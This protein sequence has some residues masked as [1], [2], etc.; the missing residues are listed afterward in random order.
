MD[1][2]N[3]VDMSLEQIFLRPINHPPNISENAD[4]LFD[5]MATL[6]GPSNDNST[7][8]QFLNATFMAEKASE[9]FNGIA[10]Q[11][12]QQDLLVP[13]GR[14]L[15]GAILYQENR[16]WVKSVAT[17]LLCIIFFFL[18][19][20][21]AVLQFVKPWNA[22]PRSPDTISAATVIL[23]TSA[24]LKASLHAVESPASPWIL[25]PLVDGRFKWGDVTPSRA[26][27]MVRA[28]GG[29]SRLSAIRSRLRDRSFQSRF[30]SRSDDIQG[31]RVDQ[32]PSDESVP[33]SDSPTKKPTLKP[34]R[35]F[36][37]KPPGRIAAIV[38]PLIII[39]ALEVIQRISDDSQGFIEVT[40]QSNTHYAMT[41][42][43][44]TMATLVALIQESIA[45]TSTIM[46]PFWRLR[47]G[48]APASSTVYYNT[49]GDMFPIA[50]WKSIQTGHWAIVFASVAAGAASF[51]SVFTTGLYNVEGVP[52]FSPI[53]L[54]RL[55]FFDLNWNNSAKEDN[56]AGTLTSLVINSNLSYPSW[57]F[58]NLA[59][60]TFA[61][62]S[63]FNTSSDARDGII[64]ARVPALRAVLNCTVT[65]PN[66]SIQNPHPEPGG[67]DEF[68]I[69]ANLRDTCPGR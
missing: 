19:L 29:A 24:D 20:G 14:S 39:V 63:D 6:S 33:K 22:A 38:A 58:D 45:S 21:S 10:S 43:P 59:F 3:A 47:M 64:T 4:F 1:L 7:L 55:D 30:S 61:V 67:N 8:G 48:N 27:E 68:I 52:T 40:S 15:T 44:A 32:L 51:L 54:D 36:I 13:D 50:I 18:I 60:P 66:E 26:R 56:G 49:V 9:A 37:I 53:S 17:I 62:A 28:S 42:V 16:L 25:H 34:W 65:L 5:L 2:Y 57:T 41:Y 46:A 69:T 11:I 23:S 12:A 35:P 31:F